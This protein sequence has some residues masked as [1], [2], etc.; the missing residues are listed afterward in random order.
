MAATRN[1]G[2]W[3]ATDSGS[4]RVLRGEKPMHASFRSCASSSS[5]AIFG[6]LLMCVPLLTAQDTTVPAGSNKDLPDAP[7]PVTPASPSQNNLNVGR[8]APPS[9][10]MNRAQGPSWRT[11]NT[12]GRPAFN[13]KVPPPRQ[14]RFDGKDIRV[15]GRP[16]ANLFS[17]ESVDGHANRMGTHGGTPWYTSHLPWAGSIMRRGIKISKAHPHLT[18][19]IKTLKPQL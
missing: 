19:V 5:I 16:K 8:E 6:L 2:C 18:T 13:T 15:A 17:F 10:D 9:F 3:P 11:S 14:S 1:M 12:V 7:M 4:G